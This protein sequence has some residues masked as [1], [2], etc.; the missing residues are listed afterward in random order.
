MAQRGRTA[1]TLDHIYS[2]MMVH[3]SGCWEWM[4]A[5]NRNKKV[6][7]PFIQGE[8]GHRWA[9]KHWVGPIPK[10]K[11]ILHSCDNTLCVC[12][13][14]LRAGTNLENHAD[15]AA[16]NRAPHKIV[17]LLD[18]DGIVNDPR[19]SYAVARELGIGATTVRRVRNA[20]QSQLSGSS[21]SSGF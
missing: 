18:I 19:S 21:N 5:S 8:L 14:H 3:E 7:R 1:F 20:H 15:K 10:G 12:P 13:D 4:G 6:R 17:H 2:L 11:H 16:R 9:Y